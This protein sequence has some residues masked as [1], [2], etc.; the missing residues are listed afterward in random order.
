M[1]CWLVAGVLAGGVC[2]RWRSS[3]QSLG[4]FLVARL[5]Y[6]YTRLWHRLRVD[7][8]GRI[9]ARGPAIVISNHASG[10]DSAFLT[11]VSPR[12]LSF[13][14]AAEFGNIPLLRRLLDAIACV[15]VHRNG[16]DIAAIR[17]SLRRLEDG[18]ALCVFPEG[19]L[20]RAGS[21]CCRR[22][23]GGAALLALR[24][25]APVIPALIR[26]GPQSPEIADAW[27]RS[28]RVRVTVG[29][30]IDLSGYSGRAVDRRLVE[31]ITDVF[32]RSIVALAKLDDQAVPFRGDLP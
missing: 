16:C 25:G 7:G 10:A 13:L 4:I 5:V 6:V 23:K 26:G 22:G 18:R 31:E 24:S 32:M 15:T 1:W 11:A 8:P 28:S 30:P 19:G 29:R 9:P 3:G 12:P 20:S 17:R 2:V 14:I 21:G 27:L